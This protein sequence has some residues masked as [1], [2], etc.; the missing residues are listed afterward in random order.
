MAIQRGAPLREEARRGREDQEEVSRQSPRH[1]GEEPQG[2]DRRPGQEE[3]PRTLR[4]H[5]RPVLFP[6]PE[7]DQPQARGRSLLLRQQRDPPYLRHHGLPV[8]GNA[9]IMSV[10]L[11][12]FCAISC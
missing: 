12:T 11:A 3:V 7:E 1:C 10:V 5:S 6:H 8:P 4:S 2:Q 9:I